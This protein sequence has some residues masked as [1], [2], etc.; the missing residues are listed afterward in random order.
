[1]GDISRTEIRLI[2]EREAQKASSILGV[3]SIT[4]LRCRDQQLEEQMQEAA[5]ALRPILECEQPQLMYL[6]HPLDWH[7]DHR[8]ALPIV[9]AALR[10]TPAPRPD[11]LTYEVMTPLTEYDRAEDITP[12][13][14]RKLRAV[15]A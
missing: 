14:E 6:T 15:R 13:M 11:L 8:A 4:F 10:D 2:R 12:F 5:A 7:P 1:A 3:S 9:Q